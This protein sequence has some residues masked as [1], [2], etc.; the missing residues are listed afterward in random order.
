LELTDKSVQAGA[1]LRNKMRY[2]A[3]R[4]AHYSEFH[5]IAHSAGNLDPLKVAHANSGAEAKSGSEHT[6]VPIESG[7]RDLLRAKRARL[8]DLRKETGSDYSSLISQIS[9][10]SVHEIDHL[11][12][13]LQGV[14]Q[15]PD[16]DRDRLHREIVQLSSTR[17]KSVMRVDAIAFAPFSYFSQLMHKLIQVNYY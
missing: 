5:R 13:G 9:S 15:K 16:N 12:A 6:V 14:R 10:H 4:V 2:V 17:R 11:I 1:G 7:M 8:S 3:S